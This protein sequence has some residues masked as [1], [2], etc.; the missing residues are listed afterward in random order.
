M[1]TK[2]DISDLDHFQMNG[3]YFIPRVNMTSKKVS[4][5]VQ[6]D[7]VGGTT[8]QRKKWFN[9]PYVQNV[10]FYFD[11]MYE[12]D[13]AR[14]FFERNEGKYFI[15]YTNAE[16][17]IVEPYVMQFVGEWNETKITGVYSTLKIDIE[18]VS[19]R[20]PALDDSLFYVYQSFGD[21]VNLFFDYMLRIVREAP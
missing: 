9:T 17:P 4:G 1:A 3:K 16:R 14:V 13:F 6:S 21:D 18:V 20:D 5:V 12:R 8:R 10:E 7:S 19:A 2:G 15:G 11:N